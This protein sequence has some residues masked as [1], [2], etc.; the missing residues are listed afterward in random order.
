MVDFLALIHSVTQGCQNE[1]KKMYNENTHRMNENKL[2]QNK[3]ESDT[4][5]DH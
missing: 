4:H 2:V 5:H 3:T 1:D